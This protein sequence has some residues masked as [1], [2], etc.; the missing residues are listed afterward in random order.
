MHKYGIIIPIRNKMEIL[1]L[2][3]PVS[4]LPFPSES[5][6]LFYSKLPCRHRIICSGRRRYGECTEGYRWP[7]KSLN[8]QNF[9]NQDDNKISREP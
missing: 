1:V 6:I 5:F 3:I 7:C 9:L 4:H 2:L 8:M